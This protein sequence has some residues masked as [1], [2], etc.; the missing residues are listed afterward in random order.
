MYRVSFCVVVD[1][2]NVT[3]SGGCVC[4]FKVQSQQS[5]C[6][7]YGWESYLR[8]GH[9][10]RDSSC[11][12]RGDVYS[13]ITSDGVASIERP[14]VI[15]CGHR[16]VHIF[17]GRGGSCLL[18][19]DWDGDIGSLGLGLC[20]SERRRLSYVDCRCVLGLYLSSRDDLGLSG[21][22]R[23][24][25]SCRLLNSLRLSEGTVCKVSV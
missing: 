18:F 14:V 13:S 3:V 16:N 17:R 15:C 2:S 10:L 20:L 12:R 11:R 19:S 24:I 23:A 9:T 25:D 22:N 5:S 8:C 4:R 7:A 21:I 1:A 6:V